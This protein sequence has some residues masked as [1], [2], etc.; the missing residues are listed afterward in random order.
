M[1]SGMSGS[2]NSIAEN[3]P[4]AAEPSTMAE[5]APHSG[6]TQSVG[7]QNSAW[8]VTVDLEADADLDEGGSRP[9]HGVLP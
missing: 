9:G 6:P 7:D 1:P 2:D 4:P 3:L 8:Q 5:K